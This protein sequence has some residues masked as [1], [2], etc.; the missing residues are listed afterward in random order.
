M[1]NPSD[2]KTRAPGSV[3]KSKYPLNSQFTTR[4]GHEMSFDDTP[5]AERI[6][7]AH[8][9]GTFTE[10]TSDG[11]K[12]EMT[13][14]NEHKY[15]K[16]NFTVT[17]DQNG[18]FVFGGNFRLVVN[19]DAHIEVNGTASVVVGGDLSALVNGSM[20]VHTEGD[21]HAT[22]SGDLAAVVDGSINASAGKDLTATIAGNMIAAVAGDSY[23]NIQGSKAL[24]IDGDFSITAGGQ[25]RMDSGDSTFITAGDAVQINGDGSNPSFIFARGSG[26]SGVFSNSNDVVIGAGGTIYTKSDGGTQL[27]ASG[28]VPPVGKKVPG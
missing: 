10:V 8:K 21:L 27:E 20:D 28:L 19:A 24:A 16:Q 17:V 4:S 9:S 7:I 2:A 22:V 11:R 23:E 25:I 26:K 15:S 14:G 12:V 13:V 1:A 6:R 3:Y 18:D 5:G